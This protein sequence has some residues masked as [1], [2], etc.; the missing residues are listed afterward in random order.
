LGPTKISLGLLVAL[1]E[2]FSERHHRSGVSGGG[3]A[4]VHGLAVVGAFSM[5]I[6]AGAFVDGAVEGREPR[7]DPGKWCLFTG[8]D[9]GRKR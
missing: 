3:D 9:E 5:P 2:P 6:Q 8:N 4:V 7:T 1:D